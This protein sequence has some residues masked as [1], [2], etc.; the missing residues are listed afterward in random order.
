MRKVFIYIYIYIEPDGS[1]DDVD[2]R[3]IFVKNVDY[4]ADPKE[5]KEHFANCGTINRV[6]ILCDPVTGHSFGYILDIYIYI[7]RYRYIYIDM[8]ILNLQK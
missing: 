3:S 6:T 7:Y 2:A 8:H 5:L 1:Q 4:A